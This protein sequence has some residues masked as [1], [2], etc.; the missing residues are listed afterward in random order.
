MNCR[1]RLAALFVVL[2]LAGC[3]QGTTGQAQAQYAP[4][5][6]ENNGNMHDSGG[7]GGGGGGM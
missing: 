4:Y 1:R 3:A 7:G 2:T 5:S 6:P